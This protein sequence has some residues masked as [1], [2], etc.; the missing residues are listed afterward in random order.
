MKRLLTLAIPAL[1]TISTVPAAAEKAICSSG[2]D[3]AG[4]LDA[5]EIDASKVAVS[6]THR[7]RYGRR[8]S[9]RE[10][11]AEVL[12][13]WFPGVEGSDALGMSF[14]MVR[15]PDANSS[16]AQLPAMIVVDWR[17]VRFAHSYVPL[18]SFGSSHKDTFVITRTDYHCARLD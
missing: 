10:E 15:F 18:L 16:T 2:P 7:Y 6:V 11:K 9:E 3:P 14:I 1:L 4:E 12:K 13:H 8:G 17:F 5:Y